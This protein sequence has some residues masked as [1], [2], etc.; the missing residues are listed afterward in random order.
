MLGLRFFDLTGGDVSRPG[1]LFGTISVVGK[2]Q[3]SW[4]ERQQND[5]YTFELLFRQCYGGGRR[6]V[7]VGKTS[8]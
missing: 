1:G 8:W 4:Q 7:R 2:S 6:V 5:F 3:L